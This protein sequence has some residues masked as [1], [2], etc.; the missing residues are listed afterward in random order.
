[1][2]TSVL[3]VANLNL[4]ETRKFLSHYSSESRRPAGVP[5]CVMDFNVIWAKMN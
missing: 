1:M 5:L 4:S 2:L 3:Y